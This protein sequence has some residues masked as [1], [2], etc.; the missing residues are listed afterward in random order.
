MEHCTGTVGKDGRKTM[1]PLQD[2][3]RTNESFS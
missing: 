1:E 3:S 2:R